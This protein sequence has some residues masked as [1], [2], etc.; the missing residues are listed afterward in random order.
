MKLFKSAGRFVPLSLCLFLGI[1]SAVGASEFPLRAAYPEVPF[2]SMADLAAEYE[3]SIIVDV[4]SEFEYDVVHIVK[5]V[6]IPFAKASFIQDLGKLRAKNA[7]QKLVFYC[8]GT[9]CPKSY[10]AVQ[11]AMDNGFRGCYV[12]D[13]GIFEWINSYPEKGVLMG[14][15]PVPSE[16]VI[17]AEKFEEK[18]I[19]IFD[20]FLLKA[21]EKNSMVIDIR[22]PIQRESIPD[23]PLLR[24]IPLDRLLPLLKQGE[25]KDKQLLII[26]HVGKQI[27]WLQYYLEDNGY[28]NYFFLEKGCLN[29][30]IGGRARVGS[31]KE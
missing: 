7:A 8:N 28:E 10:D 20:D 2:I 19:P 31:L 24:N 16:K 1:I 23:V 14:K 27:R 15:T 21:L 3:D 26:D 13:A 29:A 9:T 25:F 4:R 17:T 18:M 11:K 6:H 5:A 22:D 12:F 30:T